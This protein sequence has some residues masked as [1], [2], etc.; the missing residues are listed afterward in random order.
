MD[1]PEKVQKKK[2]YRLLEH[3]LKCWIKL[4]TENSL[5]LFENLYGGDA[6]MLGYIVILKAYFS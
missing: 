4:Y 2:G 6:L 1:D 5:Q 3:F